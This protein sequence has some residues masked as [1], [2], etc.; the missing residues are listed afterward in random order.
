MKRELKACTIVA[1]TYKQSHSALVM[2]ELIRHPE[3][4]DSG[5]RR[6]DGVSDN[7]ETVNML[8]TVSPTVPLKSFA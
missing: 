5:F 1:A 3:A 6:N 7:R 2:P 4:L 8:S